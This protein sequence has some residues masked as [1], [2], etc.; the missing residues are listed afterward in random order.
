MSADSKRI[1]SEYTD[2]SEKLLAFFALVFTL[3][4]TKVIPMCNLSSIVDISEDFSE[5]ET[6]VGN[7]Y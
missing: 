1:H 2:I 7:F 4:E 3:E 5:T 6:T